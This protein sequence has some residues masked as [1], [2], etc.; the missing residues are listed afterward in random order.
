MLLIE[1]IDAL[2]R[3]VNKI[4]QNYEICPRLYRFYILNISNDCTLLI[5]FSL[6]EKYSSCLLPSL[7]IVEKLL[8]QNMVQYRSQV[9]RHSCLWQRLVVIQGIQSQIL[10]TEHAKPTAPGTIILQIVYLIVSKVEPKCIRLEHT[11]I[12]KHVHTF[13]F[14]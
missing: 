14:I 3:S 8:H 11:G 2:I 7:Q 12:F 9:E 13:V 6:N 4:G 5:I 1:R 10:Q